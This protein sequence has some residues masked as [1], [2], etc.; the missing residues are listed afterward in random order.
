M[1]LTMWSISAAQSRAPRLT[2]A[3][4]EAAEE[5]SVEEEL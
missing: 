3:F 4:W 5:L 2:A 1:N